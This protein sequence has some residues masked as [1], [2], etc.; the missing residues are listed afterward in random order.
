VQNDYIDL[1]NALAPGHVPAQ[2]I[3]RKG[4]SV[5]AGHLKLPAGLSW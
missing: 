2:Q 5:T 4:P 3:D 1:V